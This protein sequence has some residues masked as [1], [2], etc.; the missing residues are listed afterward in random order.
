ML[1]MWGTDTIYIAAAKRER[2]SES[3][4]ERAVPQKTSQ[5]DYIGLKG[6]GT[7]KEAI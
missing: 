4:R 5:W 3:E 7:A 1:S 2:E 6:S